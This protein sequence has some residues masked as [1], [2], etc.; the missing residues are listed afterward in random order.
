MPDGR[1]CPSAWPP[2]EG[3]RAG[4]G[5]AAGRTVAPIIAS[6]IEKGGESAFK[7]SPTRFFALP[8]VR[9]FSFPF[10]FSLACVAESKEDCEAVLFFFLLD[11]K[12][13]KKL[14]FFFIL[15]RTQ[16][17]KG[18]SGS[19]GPWFQRRFLP[20]SLDELCALL[21]R[22]NEGGAALVS[23]CRE[24][25]TTGANAADADGLIE[26]EQAL[27]KLNQCSSVSRR[28]RRC[29]CARRRAH[30]WRGY[31]EGNR[32]SEVAPK[33]AEELV[34]SSN[35]MGVSSVVVAHPRP[36]RLRQR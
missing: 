13:G 18:T 25:E 35:L 29:A 32:E 31:V 33:R 36:R 30:W 5:C 15:Q 34:F 22:R 8:L 21:L 28:L 2:A 20:V 27:E 14:P 1:L 19:T 16:T 12:R 6:G 3:A 24:T 9:L 10:S 11:E 17:K 4:R 26:K 7:C 23:A